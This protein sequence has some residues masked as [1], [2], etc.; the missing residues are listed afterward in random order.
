MERRKREQPGSESGMDRRDFLKLAPGMGIAVGAAVAL[1]QAQG[2]FMT[3]ALAPSEALAAWA[4]PSKEEIAR[5]M[6]AMA[7]DMYGTKRAE[8]LRKNIDDTATRLAA[9][10]KWRFE[11][12]EEEPDFALAPVVRKEVK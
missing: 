1:Q 8:E 5:N 12:T 6:F 4:E 9:Q 10:A 11:T 3:S 2:G 7:K